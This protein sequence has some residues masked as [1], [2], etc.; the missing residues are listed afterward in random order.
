[1]E[2]ALIAGSGRVSELMKGS[3]LRSEYICVAIE[4]GGGCTRGQRCLSYKQVVMTVWARC[5]RKKEHLG[6]THTCRIHCG[7]PTAGQQ[8]KIHMDKIWCGFF[9]ADFILQTLFRKICSESAT[10]ERT[11]TVRDDPTV[12]GFKDDLPPLLTFLL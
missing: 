6:Y 5:R 10:C 9:S 8:K 2:L 7:S 1:M 3:G 4:V 12:T 11:R